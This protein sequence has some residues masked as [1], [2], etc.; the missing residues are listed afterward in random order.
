MTISIRKTIPV[1]SNFYTTG[2]DQTITLNGVTEIT[3]HSKKELIKVSKPKAKA[4]QTS[5]PSDEFD[6]MIVD[7]KKGTD[8]VIIRGYLED[9]STTTA[10]EKFWQLRA[11]CSRGGA[12]TSLTIDNIIFSSTTQQAFLE[13]ITAIFKTDD[14]GVLN[15]LTINGTARVEISM[16]FFIGDER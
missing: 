9:D 11:M 6:N 2:G 15:T 12:L 4:R 13:D 16:Q 8:E 1:S 5:S 3:I 10:W 7:L 14:M